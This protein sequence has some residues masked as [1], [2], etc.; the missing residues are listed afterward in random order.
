M[1]GL[2]SIFNKTHQL[3]HWLQFNNYMITVNRKLTF[4]V[5]FT[6][7]L[8]FV[9]FFVGLLQDGAC[10]VFGEGANTE[11]GYGC[12]EYGSFLSFY[13]GS[14]WLFL[15][16]SLV[17]LGMFLGVTYI[18]FRYL[19][20]CYKKWNIYR[21][22]GFGTFVSLLV[23]VFLSGLVIMRSY[24]GY[25]CLWEFSSNCQQVSL[26]NYVFVRLI[27]WTGVVLL[28]FHLGLFVVLSALFLILRKLKII[29]K[30]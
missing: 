15:L 8:L 23:W 11:T 19:L 24:E 27:F 17:L 1:L 7:I 14:Y 20:P 25:T 16:Q 18:I 29:S 13:G 21:R 9:I 28:P 12:L 6:Q 22:V 30:L 26:L 2:L 3:F 5:F 10:R 4:L